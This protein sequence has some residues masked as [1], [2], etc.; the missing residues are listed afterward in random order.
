LRAYYGYVAYLIGI[1]E[2][3]EAEN[4]IEEAEPY[5][6][7]L[8]GYNAYQSP[9]EALHGAFI[10]YKIG[11]NKARAVFLGPQS[12]KHINN[13]IEID[14]DNPKGWIEKGNAE[15]HM[16]RYLGGSYE[17]AAKYYKKA[18]AYFEDNDSQSKCSWIYLNALA[19]L[20]QSYDKMGEIR[21]ARAT[22]QK[23][24]SVEPGFTWVSDELYPEFQKDH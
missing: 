9:A 12:M 16:P 7:R 11:I 14:P 10:A 22:Y 17:Q 20:A 18:I 8:K 24:L 21:K 2:D 5:I 1:E 13:A 3:D 19:W 6:E 23:I 15:Y 4:Y